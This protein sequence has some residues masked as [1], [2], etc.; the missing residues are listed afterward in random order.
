M[1]ERIYTFLNTIPLLGWLSD[2]SMRDRHWKELQ[3]EIK[4]EF[5][6]HDDDFN[7]G[8][9]ANLNLLQ[10]QDKIEE[11]TSHAKA[12]LKIEKSLDNIENL[13]EHSPSTNL[14]I[15]VS[16][17]KGSADQCYKVATTENI[18]NL[19][20]E[21]SG[22]L[23]EHKSSPFYK[24]F[25]DKIDM[26]ENN[27]AKITDTLEILTLVQERWQYLESIFGGQQHIQKQLAQ[28]YS[29]FKQVDGTFR[30]EMQRIY[31]VKNAYRALVEDARDFITV[32]NGLN[33]HLEIVQKKLNDLLAAKRV[34]FPRFYFLSNEDL[35]EMIGQAKNPTTINKHI[36]KIFE[37]IHAIKTE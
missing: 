22:K 17:T 16:Y 7:L 23:A 31:K 13:W 1:N 32:L 12:Q 3:L 37:G 25:D 19:I 11:I 5:N 18:V 10:H 30:Q 35:L 28:E 34:N 36:K 26:W 33:L 24:Q 9:V 15:E 4:E 14:E 21:H 20:E 2:E 29:I 8:K 27:I 6:W